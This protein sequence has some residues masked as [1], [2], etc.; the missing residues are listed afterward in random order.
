MTAL[1]ISELFSM[2]GRTALITGASGGLGGR[3]AMALAA[4]GAKVALAG[5]RLEPMRRL[6]HQLREDGAQAEIIE[7]DV[8]DRA[9]VEAGL[10]LAASTLGLVDVV[11]NNSGVASNIKALDQSDD[12][13][14]RVLKVNLD[15]A[16]LVSMAMAKR[17]IKAGK[18]GAIVNIASILGLRQGGAVTAYAVSKAGL[19]QMTKQHALEWARHDIRVNAIAPGYVETDMNREFFATEAGAA[20]VQRLPQ[21]RLGQAEELDG[22]LLLLASNASAYITGAVLAVDGGHLVTSL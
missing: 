8:T 7:M 18:P 13:W 21:R 2:A 9:S 10:D 4:A 1:K 14:G 15:G 12:D 16:R 5:R 17:L 3:F 22:A 19:I 20:L 11:V 6:A